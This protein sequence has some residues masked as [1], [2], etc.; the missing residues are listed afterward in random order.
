MLTKTAVSAFV[1]GVDI[2]HY[3]AITYWKNENSMPLAEDCSGTNNNN[4]NPICKAPEC[5]KTS[6]AA[7]AEKRGAS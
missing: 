1:N 3:N 7:R 2:L 4:N 6:V 5:Q